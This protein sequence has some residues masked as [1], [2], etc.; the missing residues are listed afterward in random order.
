MTCYLTVYFF[1][2]RKRGSE[3]SVLSILLSYFLFF[4]KKRSSEK[5]VLSILLSSFLFLKRKRGSEK[6]VLSILLSSFLFFEK[7]RGSEKSVNPFLLSTFMLN[8]N[9]QPECLPSRMKNNGLARKRSLS[10][11][12][13]KFPIHPTH[14][15]K[16]FSE[17]KKILDKMEIRITI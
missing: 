5:S 16:T 17:S 7:K 10:F 9:G 3:K 12:I 8:T 11:S 6:S 13:T 1:L 4:E 2:K 14:C 15:K